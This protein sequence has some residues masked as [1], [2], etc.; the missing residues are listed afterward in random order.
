MTVTRRVVITGLGAITPVG[1]TVET[2][3]EGV[4]AGRS[5]IGWLSHFDTTDFKVKVAGEVRDWK[6]MDALPAK[7]VRRRDRYQVLA[8]AVVQQ[9]AGHAGITPETLETD[10]QR[11]RAGA[12]VGSA[13]GGMTTFSEQLHNIDANGPRRMSPFGIPSFMT[14]TGSSSA[15]MMLGLWGSSYI[16]TSACATGAD[17]I[18]HAFDQIRLGR[19]DLMFAG[20]SEAPI[21]PNSIAGFDR[22]GACSHEAETP[23]QA[24]RPFDVARTG[25]VVA[26]GAAVLVLEALGTARARGAA[27][28]GEIIGYGS[29]SDAYHIVAPHPQG[30]GAAAAMRRALADARLEAEDVDYINAH[31]TATPLNDTMETYA[32]KHALGETA[33][34]IPV[35]S[36]KSVTGHAMGATAAMEAVFSVMAIRDQVAPPTIN[37]T[38][39]DPACDLDYIPNEAREMSIRH[40]VSNSFGFGGHNAVLVFKAFED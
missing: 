16:L 32:I 35:S 2:S 25:L 27:I 15:S 24:M 30:R 26:E 22:L 40:V 9:A 31:G 34:N 37:L 10:E 11:A 29:T 21:L 4:V 39:P 7:E 38:D 12:C 17:C 3:W 28:L 18:G 6:P 14:T 20:A 5:G 8:H 1:N 23:T 13:I 36:T 19:A 33:Y